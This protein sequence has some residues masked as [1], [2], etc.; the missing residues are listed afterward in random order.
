MPLF[1]AEITQET[2]FKQYWRKQP[3]VFRDV[4]TDSV[5]LLQQCTQPSVLL[6]LAGREIVESRIVEPPDYKLRLGPF[7]LD[8]LPGGAL[9]MIQGLD[10]YLDEINEL[11]HLEFSFLPRWRIEDV[12]VTSGSQGANCGAHFDHYD[13]FLVQVRG[14]K[15]WRLDTQDHVDDDLDDN[16]SIRLL[17]CFEPVKTELLAPGDVLYVP[18]GIGHWGLSVDDS[19]T[20]SVGI[21]NPTMQEL[22]SNLA[23]LIVEETDSMETLDDLMPS[24]E[25]GLSP[26]GLQNLQ[27]RLSEVMLDTHLIAQWYGTYVTE[28][29]EPDTV[30]LDTH[31][32]TASVRQLL[33][34][35]YS[36]VCKRST[37]LTYYDGDT[38]T[39][40]ING[41]AFE[42][43]ASVKSWLEPLCIHRLVLCKNVTNKKSNIDLLQALINYGAVELR[44]EEANG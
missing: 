2:F 18:P 32:D 31:L 3:Y 13:V 24:P 1:D 9:L 12:M 27:T 35:N 16:A 23:D 22:V 21:R 8:R 33:S 37:R 14:S 28:P 25:G 30:E 20:L 38:F 19:I 41:D 36:I 17:K 44:R 10:Q 39:A 7:Q 42:C 5:S 26:E 43:D 15:E 11:L 29:R 40:F 6:E 34:R 4:C